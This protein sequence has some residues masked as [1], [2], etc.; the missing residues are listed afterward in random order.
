MKGEKIEN[1]LIDSI[2]LFNS[3]FCLNSSIKYSGT[4]Y[5]I[6]KTRERIELEGAGIPALFFMVNQT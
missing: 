6:H 4:Y 3:I 2:L 1:S 5:H